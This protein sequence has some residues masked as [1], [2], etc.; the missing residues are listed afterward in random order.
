M[1]NVVAPTAVHIYDVTNLTNSVYFLKHYS[2]AATKMFKSIKHNDKSH[3][4]YEK[5]KLRILLNYV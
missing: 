1:L 5:E 3:K 4:S 2:A